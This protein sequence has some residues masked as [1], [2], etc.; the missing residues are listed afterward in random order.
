MAHRRS[1]RR[2]AL[3]G[4]T[5][6]TWLATACGQAVPELTDARDIVARTLIATSEVRTAHV[7]ID[8]ENRAVGGVTDT[9]S[10]EASVNLAEGELAAQGADRNGGNIFAVIVAGGDLFARGGG[11]EQWTRIP[12]A[13]LNPSI[14]FTLA[15][16]EAGEPPDYLALLTAVVTDPRTTFELRGVEDCDPGRCYHTVIAITREQVWPLVI[17][18][19]GLDAIPGGVEPPPP[20]DL[21][22]ISIEVLTDMATLRLVDL[23]G[24]A[25]VNDGNS[26]AI[27]MRVS[28]VNQDVVIEAPLDARTPPVPGF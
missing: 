4:I 28:A 1:P 6:L 17:E 14:L 2:A 18:L 10:I 26:V 11:G 16:G 21:P 23:V 24:T 13:G 22:L 12:E 3:V 25:T 8:L 20:G 7:L 9:A 27:R 5:T 15:R 19:A